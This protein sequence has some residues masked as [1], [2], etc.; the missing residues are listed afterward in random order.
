[1]G[2]DVL[3]HHRFC[4]RRDKSLSMKRVLVVVWPPFGRVWRGGNE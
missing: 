2:A 3:G 4:P 1:M